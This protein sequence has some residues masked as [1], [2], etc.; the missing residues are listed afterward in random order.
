MDGIAEVF[1]G[2]VE[3]WLLH[4][5]GSGM[6]WPHHNE[7]RRRERDG[8]GRPAA[9]QPTRADIPPSTG[10]STPVMKLA[11]SEAR[12]SAAWAVSQPVP[13][14]PRNGTRALRASRTSAVV[15]PVAAAI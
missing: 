5:A 10:N 1:R 7:T 15:D 4:G 9:C 14:L 8:S 13:I 6:G 11:S 2:A 12:N 3:M